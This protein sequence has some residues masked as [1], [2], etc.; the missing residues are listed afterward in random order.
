MLRLAVYWTGLLGALTASPPLK[1]MA[2]F[3]PMAS[4][5][6]QGGGRVGGAGVWGQNREIGLKIGVTLENCSPNCVI[7][8]F[9]F[10]NNCP[11]DFCSTSWLPLSFKCRFYNAGSRERKIR[12]GMWEY[13]FAISVTLRMGI[14]HEHQQRVFWYVARTYGYG[15]RYFL[16]E[17]VVHSGGL[18]TSTYDNTR[19]MTR[20]SQHWFVGYTCRVAIILAP[21]GPCGIS[22]MAVK[23]I[24]N[25]EWGG[26]AR[27][28]WPFFL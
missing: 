12:H 16:D 24:E 5:T 20:K 13:C 28:L 27:R 6:P 18:D 3:L 21:R 15:L 1:S 4:V 11:I 8:Y 7:F 22:S 23:L 9:S 25:R 2:Q 26:V 10:Q 14:G 19:G 17:P